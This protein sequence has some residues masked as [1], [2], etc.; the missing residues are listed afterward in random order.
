VLE[1][2]DESLMRKK[3]VIQILKTFEVEELKQNSKKKS[4]DEKFGEQ[5]ELIQPII[6]HD[7]QQ[8]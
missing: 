6:N 5:F 3:K 7:N 8:N 4:T 2:R 1:P